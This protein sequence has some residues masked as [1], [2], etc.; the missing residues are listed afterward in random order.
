MKQIFTLLAV[1][2]MS[3]FA[4][5]NVS[6]AEAEQITGAE[7]SVEAVAEAGDTIEDVIYANSTVT[8]T[9]YCQA[10]VESSVLVIGDGDT[11]LDLYIYDENGNLVDS[12][13]DEWDIG[14]CEWTPRRSGTFTIKIRNWGDVYNRCTIIS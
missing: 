10:G 4:I 9:M 6:A 8:Y 13:T 11:D 14:L 3:M 5:E 2:T 12:T 1:A 7:A